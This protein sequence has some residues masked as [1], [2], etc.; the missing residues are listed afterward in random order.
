[1][2]RSSAS[3]G[4]RV[5]IR[6]GNDLGETINVF[7]E[8]EGFD[9]D[10]AP[11]FYNHILL[12]SVAGCAPRPKS[13]LFRRFPILEEVLWRGTYVRIFPNHWFHGYIY[14]A[15]G[16]GVWHFSPQ[17]VFPNTAPGGS[18]SLVIVA[19]LVGLMW[20]WAARRSGSILWNV[21]RVGSC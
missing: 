18:V 4:T 2:G 11:A 10:A 6:D 5:G 9:L 17:S 7:L 12:L 19:G 1:M 13:R 20:G 15:I 3:F 14:P 21:N 16:F 8:T